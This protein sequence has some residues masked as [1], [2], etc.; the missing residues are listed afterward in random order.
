MPFATIAQH[1]YMNELACVEVMCAK[2]CDLLGC[3][4]MT[5]NLAYGLAALYIYV[6]PDNDVLINYRNLMCYI[7]FILRS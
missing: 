6:Y 5:V 4:I 2:L 1:T 7:L 3:I